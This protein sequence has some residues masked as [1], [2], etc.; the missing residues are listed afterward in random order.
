[1]NIPHIS[2]VLKDTAETAD[3]PLT[4]FPERPA[5]ETGRRLTGAVP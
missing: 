1:V 3:T 5:R 2:T 4:A